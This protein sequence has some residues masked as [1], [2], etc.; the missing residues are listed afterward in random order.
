GG[1]DLIKTETTGEII[2]KHA[3]VLGG[4][5]VA[6]AGIISLVSVWFGDEW[7]I[8]NI[9]LAILNGFYIAI[10]IY[11]IWIIIHRREPEFLGL[12]KV[13]SIHD[14]SILIVEGAPWLSLSVMTAIYLKEDEFE[15]LVCV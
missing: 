11:L 5:L 1:A 9:N 10:G 2:F 7:R 14:K 6:F 8:K 3:K 12:P 13:I 15:R 4:L